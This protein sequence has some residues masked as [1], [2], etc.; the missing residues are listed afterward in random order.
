MARKACLHFPTS[1]YVAKARG[2]QVFIVKIR[3]R[4]ITQNQ[5]FARIRC[6]QADVRVVIVSRMLPW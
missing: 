3:A 1:Q 6:R 2:S 5:T 4:K